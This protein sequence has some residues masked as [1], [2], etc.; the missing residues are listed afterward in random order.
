MANEYELFLLFYLNDF[1]AIQSLL[2]WRDFQEYDQLICC[3]AS[4]SIVYI[5]SDRLPNV[6]HCNSC[7]YI[8]AYLPKNV[9]FII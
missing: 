9:L 4:S 1:A 2:F 3:I 8:Q 7:V 5:L 6:S